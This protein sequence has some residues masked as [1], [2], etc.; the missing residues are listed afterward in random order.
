MIKLLIP[1][2]NKG[3]MLNTGTVISLDTETENKLIKAQSAETF[4]PE[5]VQ[6]QTDNESND[7]KPLSELSKKEL[8]KLAESLGIK[9]LTERTSNADIIARIEAH[10]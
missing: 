10:E 9:D 1:F 5:T 7:D 8:L 4:V 3:V 6:T 2:N